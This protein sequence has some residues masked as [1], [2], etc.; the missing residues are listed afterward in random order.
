[1]KIHLFLIL[2]FLSETAV[3]AA[4]VLQI[5]VVV[6]ACFY[7]AVLLVGLNHTWRAC[8]CMNARIY[9]SGVWSTY[10]LHLFLYSIYA[11]GGW[12][13]FQLWLSVFLCIHETARFSVL[14]CPVCLFVCF[15]ILYL[16]FIRCNRHWFMFTRFFRSRGW[17][18]IRAC[19]NNIAIL[20]EVYYC[21]I[22][23]LYNI[24]PWFGW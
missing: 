2:S 9:F 22:L 18:D 11:Q 20:F 7:S 19:N 13:K 16:N 1:M 12:S 4:A 17:K 15:V 10:R 5:I 6:F 14:P 3:L 23:F 8:A 24:L 21:K